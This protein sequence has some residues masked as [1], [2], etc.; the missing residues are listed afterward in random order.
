[1]WKSPLAGSEVTSKL[2]SDRK[3]GGL[4]MISYSFVTLSRLVAG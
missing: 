2:V 3:V 4:Q 1:M